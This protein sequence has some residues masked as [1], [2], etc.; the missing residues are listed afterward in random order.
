[1]LKYIIFFWGNIIQHWHFINIYIKL[2]LAL[3][4]LSTS[5]LTYSIML[6]KVE[7]KIS[8]HSCLVLDLFNRDH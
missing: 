1:M 8:L 6:M 3:I 4:S 5:I 7:K 2:R